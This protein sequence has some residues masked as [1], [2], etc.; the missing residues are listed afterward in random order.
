MIVYLVD[1]KIKYNVLLKYYIGRYEW[2]YVFSK[3]WILKKMFCSLWGRKWRNQKLYWIIQFTGGFCLSLGGRL[4][5]SWSFWPNEWTATII[6]W[7]WYIF[8][9]QNNNKSMAKRPKKIGSKKIQTRGGAKHPTI[10][11]LIDGMRLET[12]RHEK[13]TRRSLPNTVFTE[14]VFEYKCVKGLLITNKSN[15]IL[16]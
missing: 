12:S 14:K 6:H 1:K 8:L 15:T 3:T 16:L 7:Y 5:C 13:R 10:R 4:I 11:K 9:L 2:S